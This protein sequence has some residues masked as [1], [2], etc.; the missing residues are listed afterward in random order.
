MDCPYSL[1]ESHAAVDLLDCGLCR[2]ART[3]DRAM[4]AIAATT[5]HRITI[6]TGRP[7]RYAGSPLEYASVWRSD[8]SSV[9]CSTTAR[10]NAAMLK[11]LERNRKPISPATSMTNTSKVELLSA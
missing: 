4:R 9:G 3:V 6:V 2:R 1:V 11:P 10:T 8:D 5:T 7:S